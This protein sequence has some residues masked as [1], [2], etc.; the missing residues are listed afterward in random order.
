MN[1]RVLVTGAS[2][3]LGSHLVPLLIAEGLDVVGMDI[4][5][6]ATPM[7]R[8]VQGNLADTPTLERAQDG[9]DLIIHCAS[10]HPWKP[11]T[12]D[13]YFD[14]NVKGTWGL[15]TTAAE[16]GIGRIVLTSSIAAV[17]YGPVRDDGT[18]DTTRWPLDEDY[19]G[20][21]GDLYSLTKNAQ[22][23]T[24]KLFARNRRVRTLALRPPAFMPR[25]EPEPGFGLMGAWA[26]V[27][28]I[29]SAHLAAVRVMLGTTGNVEELDW[30]EA[31]FTTNSVPY[32]SEDGALMKNGQ[33]SA[34]MVAKYWPEASDW[35]T[36]YGPGG[37]WL[38]AVYDLTKA[39]AI[40]A[41]EPAH[42]FASWFRERNG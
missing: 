26:K 31:F 19:T 30:F 3:H 7:A 25:P 38:P 22:E 36:E 10:V 39:R 20:A 34:G 12:D 9:V 33:V 4:A 27:E 42:D 1:A 16:K 35:F 40:L 24:A 6:P 18:P 14:L 21:P 29:A 23:T 17:G 32:T 28:D 15:Y 2:G 41:W 11:Y 5:L 8:F 13:Q 37:I